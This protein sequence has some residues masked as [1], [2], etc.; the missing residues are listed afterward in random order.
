MYD[1]TWAHTKFMEKKLIFVQK[2]SNIMNIIL[3]RAAINDNDK[4]PLPIFG[5]HNWNSIYLKIKKKMVQLIYK[6]VFV[7][8]W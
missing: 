3:M 1:L 2:I 5:I 8:N 4:S 7:F 6:N